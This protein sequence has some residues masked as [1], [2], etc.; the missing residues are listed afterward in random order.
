[1]LTINHFPLCY[2]KMSKNQFICI[3]NDIV[4]LYKK[5]LPSNCI[6]EATLKRIPKPNLW[7][8]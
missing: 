1:M 8:M 4:N 7:T 6:N 3:A 2:L 5:M